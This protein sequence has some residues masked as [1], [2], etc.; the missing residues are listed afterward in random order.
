VRIS[1]KWEYAAKGKASVHLRFEVGEEEGMLYGKKDGV[2]E[3][4]GKG[5]SG[6]GT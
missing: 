3:A 4:K 6:R 5:C 1:E 2:K